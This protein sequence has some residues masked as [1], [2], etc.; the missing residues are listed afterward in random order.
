MREETPPRSRRYCGNKDIL[1]D[2][3][4]RFG[5]RHECLRTGYGVCSKS[6]RQGQRCPLVRRPD[7][8][9]PARRL[10]CG[11]NDILP[12]GYTAFGSLH[13]CLKKGFGVCLYSKKKL[14]FLNTFYQTHAHTP[15]TMRQWLR[16]ILSLPPTHLNHVLNVFH[17]DRMG[18]VYRLRINEE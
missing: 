2:G 1:P 13:D 16:I 6:G 5:T 15:K 8:R 18:D 7:N 14:D 3:Y 17:L 11:T 10:Y 9:R 12:E 4:T